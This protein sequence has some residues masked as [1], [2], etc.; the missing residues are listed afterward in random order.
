[1]ISTLALNDDQYI[2][3]ESLLANFVSTNSHLQQERKKEPASLLA[4]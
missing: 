2:E 3:Q 4:P 1:M